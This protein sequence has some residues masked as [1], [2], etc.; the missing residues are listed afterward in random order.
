MDFFWKP[1]N[2]RSI[3]VVDPAGHP[4]VCSSSPPSSSQD[5]LRL[6]DWST[7]LFYLVNT[8][9]SYSLLPRD[10]TQK[11]SVPLPDRALYAANGST[12]PVY[13]ERLCTLDLSLRRQF[14]W[15]FVVA[16]VT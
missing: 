1:P 14:P 13:G 15:V 16:D 5:V 6:F 10:A 8:G 2:H 3:K 4:P 12:I 11:S 9:A 7:N